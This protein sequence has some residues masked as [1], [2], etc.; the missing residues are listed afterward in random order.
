MGVDLARVAA[1]YAAGPKGHRAGSGYLVGPGRVLTAAH[2]VVDAGLRRGDPAKISP[3]GS[4]K[5]LQA[6]IIWLDPRDGA[7][8][9][10]IELQDL[11]LDP[12]IG[13]VVLWRWW[14]VACLRLRA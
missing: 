12:P 5:W 8:A 1:I 3:S 14:A 10:L 9:A 2:V 7:D 11:S 4:G 13:G 6:K